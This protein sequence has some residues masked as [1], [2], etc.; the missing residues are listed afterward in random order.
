M[1]LLHDVRYSLRI[2]RRSPGTAAA[3]VISLA[4]GIG[5]N[6]AIYSWVR[7]ILLEPLPGVARQEDIV[8]VANRSRSGAW[9][10]LSYP[11]YVDLRDTCRTLEGLAVD[12]IVTVSLGA[13]GEM[14]DAERL[15]GS[16]VSG[17]YFDVLRVGMTLGRGFTRAEEE[18]PGRAPVAVLS[19]ALWQRRFA[20][21]VAI[22]G[23]TIQLNNKPYT[24]V[25]VASPDFYGAWSGLALDLWIPVVMQ[26]DVMPGD[27][28]HARGNRWLQ[29]LGRLGPGVT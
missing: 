13:S 21:D 12:S 24:V 22:V 15:Y 16:L 26:A 19:H 25:G 11:D 14:Q 27:L 29:G 3:A 2:L 1:G 6:G 4:L 10:T 23:K 9:R 18:A 7:S 28:I 17:N 8:V 20:S 5:A